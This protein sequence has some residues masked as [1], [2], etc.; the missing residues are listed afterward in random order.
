LD[1]MA[2]ARENHQF[3]GVGFEQGLVFAVPAS[4]FYSD[5]WLKKVRHGC[6]AVVMQVP[7][8]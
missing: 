1:N 7:C 3:R 4:T 5:H 2:E 8:A 6:T